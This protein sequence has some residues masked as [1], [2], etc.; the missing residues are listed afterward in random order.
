MEGEYSKFPFLNFSLLL[1]FLKKV[2]AHAM[3]PIEQGK[4]VSHSG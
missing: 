3:F 1:F 2:Q 4:A